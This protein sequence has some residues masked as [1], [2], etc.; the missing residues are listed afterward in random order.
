ML[1]FLGCLDP[2][3]TP[4]MQSKRTLIKAIKNCN[5]PLLSSKRVLLLFLVHLSFSLSLLWLRP[6]QKRPS[7][8]LS[9]SLWVVNWFQFKRCYCIDLPRKI[10]VKDGS[11]PAEPANLLACVINYSPGHH[12]A[13]M[14]TRQN[15]WKSGGI[16]CQTLDC[17]IT[18]F[19][20][21]WK[22]ASPFALTDLS[23]LHL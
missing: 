20:R 2:M 9:I 13:A 4:I 7:R 11:L 6:S 3:C 5:S 14:H 16:Y 15:K 8:S 21:N 17:K 19:L 10:F 22:E 23:N 12:N 18:N 1:N